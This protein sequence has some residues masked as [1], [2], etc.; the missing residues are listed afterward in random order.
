MAATNLQPIVPLDEQ[1]GK[2][3]PPVASDPAKTLAEILRTILERRLYFRLLVVLHRDLPIMRVHPTC[4]EVVVVCIKLTSPPFL[5][6]EAMSKCIVL[7]DVAAIRNGSTGKTW[8]ASIDVQASRT[9]EVSSLE[10]CGAKETP[11]AR[12]PLPLQSLRC[13]NPTHSRVLKRG[14]HPRQQLGRQNDIVVNKDSDSSRN[15][16]NGSA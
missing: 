1:A 2:I 8:Q 15:L 6:R 12:S 3:T 10:I 14:Q 13:P 11:N 4:D 7:Q 9:V 5:V 16:R